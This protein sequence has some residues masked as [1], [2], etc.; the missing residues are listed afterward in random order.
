ME[1]RAVIKWVKIF[2]IGFLILSLVGLADLVLLSTLINVTFDTQPYNIL[3]IIFQSGFMSFHAMLLWIILLSTFCGFIVFSFSIFKVVNRDTV[4]DDKNLAKFLLLIGLFLIIGGF[5][6]M[7][8]I[9]LLGKSTVN[10][11]ITNTTFQIA[12]DSPSITPIFGTL[13]WFYFNIATY[14]FLVSGLI[15]GGI[16]LKWMLLVQEEEDDTNNKS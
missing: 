3:T 5:I 10:T 6:T 2:S 16:G 11:G 4:V 7:N 1:R 9:V 12:L 13:M 14:C 15:F 8:F